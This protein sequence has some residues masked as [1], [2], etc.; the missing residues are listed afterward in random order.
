L[1]RLHISGPV[2]KDEITLWADTAKKRHKARPQYLGVAY[3]DQDDDEQ[4]RRSGCAKLDPVQI[5][6]SI[7]A[8][9]KVY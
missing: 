5:Y 4:L 9:R 8:C 6:V 3:A 1:D 2:W 7:N